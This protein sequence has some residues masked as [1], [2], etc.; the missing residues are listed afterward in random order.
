[1]RFAIAIVLVVLYVFIL[2]ATTKGI[3]G[4]DILIS[5]LVGTLLAPAIIA[6]LFCIPRSG[7]NNKRFFS[8]FNAVLFLAIAG[9][10]GNLAAII[11]TA[12]KPPQKINGSNNKV[13]IIVPG[14][15]VSKEVP[16]ENI[17]LNISNGSEYLNII[18]A[19]EFTG[20]DRLQ[21]DDYAKLIGD[22]F[23]ASA[24]DFESL[25]DIKKCGSTKMECVYQVANTTTG[26]KGTT[27][28]L[29]SLRGSD[30]YYNFMAITNP[31]LLDIYTDDIFNA[32]RS[33]NETQK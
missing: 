4:I 23:R 9:Q 13:E 20:T 8:V 19:Y 2:L 22:N 32:L 3:E 16:N 31:G 10:S 27:T 17:G 26:E 30:G 33:L 7:R 28:I 12:S 1:M 6:G 15:W 5:Y 11:E 29:A 25:S 18:V 24:P 21:L 14:S